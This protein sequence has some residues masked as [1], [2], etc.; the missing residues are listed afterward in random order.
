MVSVP[1]VD[2][3][4]KLKLDSAPIYCPN[5][6]Y[7][8]AHHFPFR[9]RHPHILHKCYYSVCVAKNFVSFSNVSWH[10]VIL[11][12]GGCSTTS[13]A[14]SLCL[15]ADIYKLLFLL[16]L[17]LIHPLFPGNNYY[18]SNSSGGELQVGLLRHK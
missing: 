9:R 17:F 8:I 12:L 16:L 6:N 4:L 18:M 1:K 14:A 5:L 10:S 3:K 7:I 11:L 13:W 15:K 2:N